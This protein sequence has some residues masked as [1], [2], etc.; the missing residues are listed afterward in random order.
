MNV[1]ILICFYWFDSF[2]DLIF[3]FVELVEGFDW[4]VGVLL[5]VRFTMP[6]LFWV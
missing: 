5:G 4:I 3:S 1:V 2:Y 6:A